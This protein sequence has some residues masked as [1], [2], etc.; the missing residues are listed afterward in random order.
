MLRPF[1]CRVAL[2]GASAALLSIAGCGTGE[3]QNRMAKRAEQ[4]QFVGSFESNLKAEQFILS[5]DCKLRLPTIFDGEAKAWLPNS[6]DEAGKTISLTRVQPSLCNL[7]GLLTTYE[8]FVGD[9]AAAAPLYAYFC[10]TPIQQGQKP[11]DFKSAI[12]AEI[13]R[14]GASGGKFA[15]VTVSTPD[16]KSLSWEMLSV[17]STQPFAGKP[18]AADTSVEGRFDLY[19]KS[20]GAN[21]IL[22]G[23]RAPKA[24]PTATKFFDDA[25]LAMG[26][27]IINEVQPQQSGAPGTGS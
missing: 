8:R 2:V 19:F 15:P 20:S 22:I 25:K 24:A 16:G 3:Y 21:F 27:A 5:P 9:G 14:S 4:L 7:P 13:A 18:P 11:E 10:A 12:E 17:T 6:Q 26:T 1:R 23:W